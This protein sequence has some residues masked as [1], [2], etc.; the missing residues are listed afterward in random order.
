MLQQ[1]TNWSITGSISITYEKQRE[2]ARFKWIQQQRDY[3]I[4]IFGPLN[5]KNIYITGNPHTVRLRHPNK[6]WV[7]AKT[8]EQLT[9]NQLG[10]VLPISNL[11]Y[12]ILALPA[13]TKIAAANFDQYGHLISLEQQGWQIKYSDFYRLPKTGIDLPKVIELNHQKLAIKIKIIHHI[14]S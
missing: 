10:W 7:E 9:Q 4:N 13:A 5:I 3:V 6:K 11:R 2:L 12:W 1:I 14:F 8:P